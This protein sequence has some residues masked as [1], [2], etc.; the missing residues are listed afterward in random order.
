MGPGADIL[1]IEDDDDLSSVLADL[2]G[3][4]GYA[5]ATARHGAEGLAYLEQAAK[6]PRI[7]LLD[8]T[9]PVMSGDEFCRVRDRNPR[10]AAIP[11]FLL[12]ARGEPESHVATLGV[13]R[14]FR[15][16]LDL[17]ALLAALADVL[18]R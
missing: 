17:A 8:L 18:E 15:K 1:L 13:A 9:M 2:L 6:L 4:Y 10:L 16:P 7:I 14:A 12:T 11:V 3:E 5:V